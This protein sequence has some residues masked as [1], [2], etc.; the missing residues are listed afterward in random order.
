MLKSVLIFCVCLVVVCVSTVAFT[1]VGVLVSRVGMAVV[2]VYSANIITRWILSLMPK[3]AVNPEGKA[4]LI[5]GCD[6]GFGLSLAHRLRSY[7]FHVYACC[8]SEDSQGA[9]ELSEL[10]ERMEVLKLD[11]TKYEEVQNVVKHVET[12]LG[13]RDLWCVVNN[14]GVAIFSEL[15]WC[16]MSVIEHMF[17][18]N[19]LGAVRV[20]KAFLPLLRRSRGRV[21]IVASAAGHITY[22]GFLSYSMTKHALVSLADGLRREMLK[23]NVG[24]VSIEPTMY[25]TRIAHSDVLTGALD[26]SWDKTPDAI[27]EAYGFPYYEDFKGRMQKLARKARPYLEEVVDCMEQAVIAVRPKICYRCSGPS[28]KVRYWLMSLLPTQIVDLLICHVIQPSHRQL[29][30]GSRNGKS[31]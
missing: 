13:N 30:G 26:N 17:H 18:V 14:A 3:E 1:G 5:T 21:A 24:V 27:K 16:S 29:S 23:W 28:D 4:V 19:V 6:T 11:V 22:P 7:G 31:S 12:D 10:P 15:E 8:L 25:K 20:T 2:V 9:K